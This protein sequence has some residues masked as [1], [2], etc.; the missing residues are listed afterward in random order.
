MNLPFFNIGEEFVSGDEVFIC[1]FPGAFSD[2]NGTPILSSFP[3]IRK[4]IISSLYE[5][6]KNTKVIILDVL[7]IKGFSGSP[8]IHGNTQKVIAVFSQIPGG[9]NTGFSLAYPLRQQYIENC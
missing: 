3:M 7:G 1:G 6:M 2:K 4:G 9:N 8:V 5:S